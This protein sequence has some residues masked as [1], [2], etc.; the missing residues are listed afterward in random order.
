VNSEQSHRGGATRPRRVQRQQ[1]TLTAGIDSLTHL[2]DAKLAPPQPPSGF[3]VRPRVSGLFEAGAARPLTVVSAGAGWGKTL[4]AAAWAT[5]GPAVGKLAW[6]SLDEADS[7]PRLFWS[8]VLTAL[9]RCGAVPADNDLAELIPGPIID[10]ET[11]RRI[12]YGISQLPAPFVLVLDDFHEIHDAEVLSGV[13][14]LLRY[15]LPQR[16]LVLITRMDPMLSFHRLRLSGDLAEIRV[17]DLA[18]SPEEAAAMLGQH[19]VRVDAMRL[20]KLLG[21]TE[22][23]AAGLRLAALTL[24]VDPSGSRLAEFTD[25]DVVVADYLTDQV[26]LA[27]PAPLREFLLHT[28]VL[29]LVTGDLADAVSGS[30]HRGQQHLERLA[31]ANAFVVRLGGAGHWYRYHPML[32]SMLQHRLSTEQPNIVPL[33]HRRAALWFAAHGHVVEAMRHAMSAANWKLLCELLVTRVMPRIYSVEREALGR[34]LDKLPPAE[35]E[36]PAEAH[37]CRVARCLAKADFATFGTQVSRAWETLPQLEADIRPGA[38]VV[39][40]LASTLVGRVSGD[41][42]TLIN[43]AAKALE[44][45]RGDAVTLPAVQEYTGMA[46]SNQGMGLLWSGAEREAE[47]SL[48]QALAAV[49]ATGVELTRI[50]VLGHLGLCAASVGRLREAQDQ[51]AAAVSLA[52]TRGWNSLEQVSTAYLTLALVNMHR[53]E[54]LEAERMLQLGLAAQ[55][56]R[57]DRLPLTALSATRIRVLT[58]RQRLAPARHALDELKHFVAAWQPPDLLGRW[59]GVA[60]AELALAEGDASSAVRQFVLRDE[61]TAIGDQERACLGRALIVHGNPELAEEVVAPLR[62]GA[63]D[64]GA[65]VEGWLVTAVIADLRRDDHRA[66]A[67]VQRAITLAEPEGFRRPFTLFDREQMSRLLTRAVSLDPARSKS[68][69]EILADLLQESDRTD[70]VL[71]EPLTDRELMVLEHLPAMSSNAEIAEKMYVSVNTVKAHLKALYRKLEVS[72]RRAAV[73]RARELN[74]F[75][76]SANAAA[77]R[78][79]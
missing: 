1:H 23:W 51:G 43:Q 65:Q 54:A 19:G 12:L 74:L 32:R 15:P 22:G 56:T 38:Q 13:A 34:V 76:A 31:R 39:L 5:S 72:S 40:H 75:A 29:E 66:R 44:L 58:M 37:L 73:H 24:Q 70:V 20:A 25:H 46:L 45:L 78:R 48:I 17:A 6:V 18:F 9:R 68:A 26:F 63:I 50:N 28:S 41:A 16:R 69:N 62:D 2:L 30:E 77:R 27:Q 47:A 21:H 60:E 61:E 10:E 4:A 36:A 55:P 71:A 3:L 42:T 35:G 79:G 59:L 11:I 53:G 7:E 8:Y 49:D 33:L 64:R 67:A 57:A 14:M 52:R